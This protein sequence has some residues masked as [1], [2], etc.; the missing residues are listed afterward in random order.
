MR[1]RQDGGPTEAVSNQDR[2]RG[3]VLAQPVRGSDQVVDVGGEV[4]VG[5]VALTFAQPR[6]VEAENPDPAFHESPRDA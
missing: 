5:K 6:E 4:R 2:R 1:T 3:V